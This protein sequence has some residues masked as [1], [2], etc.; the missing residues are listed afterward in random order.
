MIYKAKD[1]RTR[2]AINSQ[3]IS[4]SGKTVDVKDG[5]ITGTKEELLELELSHG[6]SI[7]GVVAE[8]KDYQVVNNPKVN[9]GKR[10]DTKINGQKV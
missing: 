9:R 4:D 2:E 1:F 8:E 10:F 7:W 3:I 5:K 6:Q